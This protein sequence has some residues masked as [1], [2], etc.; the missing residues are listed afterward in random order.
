MSLAERHTATASDVDA[1]R[2]VTESIAAAA[3]RKDAEAMKQE[4]DR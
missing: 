1:I 3:Y 4:Q 2:A